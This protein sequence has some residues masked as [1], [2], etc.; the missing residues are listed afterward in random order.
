MKYDLGIQRMGRVRDYLK[1]LPKQINGDLGTI[2]TL[3]PSTGKVH[4][5][6]VYSI[7]WV[8]TQYPTQSMGRVGYDLSTLPKCRENWSW[9]QHSIQTMGMLSQQYP[10]LEYSLGMIS[11]TLS[12]RD[13]TSQSTLVCRRVMTTDN[14]IMVYFYRPASNDSEM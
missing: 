1:N 3:H 11:V 2:L 14:K 13:V 4:K 10:S 6:R 8:W 7:T 5:K 9:S 12:I